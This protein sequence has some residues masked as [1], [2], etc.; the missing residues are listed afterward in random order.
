VLHRDVY[1]SAALAGGFVMVLAL[2]AKAPRAVAMFAA[3]GA[4]FL[5]RMLLVGHWNLPRILHL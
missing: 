4:C 1:A 2:K 3:G 5:L